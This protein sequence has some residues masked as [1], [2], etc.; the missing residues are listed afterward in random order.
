MAEIEFPG[1]IRKSG[2]CYIVTIPIKEIKMGRLSE[3]PHVFKAAPVNINK[4]QA[5]AKA[6]RKSA[7]KGPVAQPG[8]TYRTPSRFSNFAGTRQDAL[9][10]ARH[11]VIA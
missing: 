11:G 1:E 2:P 4:D 6:T 3:G 5:A 8:Q 9:S 7:K 10:Q